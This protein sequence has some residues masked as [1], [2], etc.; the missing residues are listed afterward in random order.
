L[1][2]FGLGVVGHGSMGILKRTSGL[3]EGGKALFKTRDCALAQN[4]ARCRGAA[5]RAVGML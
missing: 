3:A 4:A 1:I 2:L 5:P